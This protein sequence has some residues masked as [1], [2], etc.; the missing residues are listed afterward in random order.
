MIILSLYLILSYLKVWEKYEKGYILSGEHWGIHIK[1]F[2]NYQNCN[3][4]YI[5]DKLKIDIMSLSIW[6]RL[7]NLNKLSL[8]FT[9]NLFLLLLPFCNILLVLC[10]QDSLPLI[11]AFPNRTGPPPSKPNFGPVIAAWYTDYS[12]YRNP[13][14]PSVSLPYI[15]GGPFQNILDIDGSKL[16]HLIYAYVLIIISNF[17]FI[18]KI[19]SNFKLAVIL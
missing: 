3:Y 10:T 11:Q 2:F 14:L 16:T 19:F 6:A 7:I 8:S 4:I 12:A 1:I 17:L 15:S 5:I 13:S 18:T 9:I